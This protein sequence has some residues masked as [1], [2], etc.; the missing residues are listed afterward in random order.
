MLYP[1]EL[2]GRLEMDRIMNTR[3]CSALHSRAGE[4]Y[5]REKESQSITV[6]LTLNKSNVTLRRYFPIANLEYP[7][8]RFHIQHAIVVLECG[9][10]AAMVLFMSDMDIAL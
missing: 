4:R 6:I 1:I 7:G 8:A 9:H 10:T 5:R 2:G 3:R